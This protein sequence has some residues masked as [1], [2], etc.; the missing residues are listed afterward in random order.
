MWSVFRYVHGSR[1]YG[2]PGPRRTRLSNLDCE[3]R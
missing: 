2:L 3:G 1:W